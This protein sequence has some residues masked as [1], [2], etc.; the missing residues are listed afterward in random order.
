MKII[1]RLFELKDEEYALFQ[2]KLTPTVDKDK[3]IGVRVPNVRKLAKEL[4]NDEEVPMFLKTL[5]HNY[6]DENMLHGLLIS[7]IKDY[8][9]CLKE[10]DIFLP[11][12]DNWAVCDIMSPV[13]FK[14]NKDKLI[15]EINKWVKSD[16]VYMV[17]FGIEMLMS[18]YLDEDYDKSYLEIPLLT[19]NEDYYV[20]M[21]VAWFY[22]T[23][24]SKQWDTTIKI[25]EQ[26]KLDKWTHNKTIQKGIES[27]RITNEQKEYLRS[28][29][30]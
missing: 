18:H 4:K 13:V 10:L 21:M 20:R 12:V 14:K 2:S 30:R 17:R 8:D 6:Y 24:L 16:K 1:D 26:N 11:Y 27:Y 3:F 23:S 5:P 22:A 25:I 28:L 15:K 29:K 19:K 7:Q 9:E